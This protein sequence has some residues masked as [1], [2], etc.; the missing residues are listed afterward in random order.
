MEKNGST[1]N[2]PFSSGACRVWLDIF[3]AEPNSLLAGR[4]GKRNPSFSYIY[5]GY[6]RNNYFLGN[7]VKCGCLYFS[8]YVGGS[9]YFSCIM[10]CCKFHIWRQDNGNL[11][12][13]FLYFSRD[14][15]YGR[16]E[17]DIG[18]NFV[19]FLYDFYGNSFKVCDK[20][21]RVMI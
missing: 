17:L 12:S 1:G 18:E 19:A 10:D 16:V 2:L 9:R 8:K 11:E 13:F 6:G 5:S 7:A 4:M 15:G 14:R 21:E 20:E 3:V